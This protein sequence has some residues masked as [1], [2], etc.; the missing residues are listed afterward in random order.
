MQP[1]TLS[2]NEIEARLNYV[3]RKSINSKY[4]AFPKLRAT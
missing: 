4:T 3:L 2:Y 1:P